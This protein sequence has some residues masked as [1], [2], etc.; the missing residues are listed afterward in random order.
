MMN[1]LGRKNTSVAICCITTRGLCQ[2]TVGI[3]INKQ[4]QLPNVGKPKE[5]LVREVSTNTFLVQMEKWKDK[6]Q[7]Y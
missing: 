2:E 1:L 3:A 4:Q 5:V 7:H 6:R